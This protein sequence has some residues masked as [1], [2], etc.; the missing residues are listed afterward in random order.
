MSDMSELTALRLY[1][2]SLDPTKGAFSGLRVV[3]DALCIDLH[4]TEK[5]DQP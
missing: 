1:V 4:S 3:R 2:A 5:K